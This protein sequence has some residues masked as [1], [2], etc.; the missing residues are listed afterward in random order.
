MMALLAIRREKFERDIPGNFTNVYKDTIYIDR[1]KYVY[2]YETPCQVQ[3][4][5][6][7]QREEGGYGLNL[8]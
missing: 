1:D 8:N 7:S 6:K 5:K 4:E 3:M 2:R